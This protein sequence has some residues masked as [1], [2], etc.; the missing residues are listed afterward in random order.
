MKWNI[1]FYLLDPFQQKSR[2]PPD[3]AF[4]RTIY[5]KK[6]EESKSKSYIKSTKQAQICSC[7][8]KEFNTKQIIGLHATENARK[9]KIEPR[10]LLKKTSVPRN[11]QNITD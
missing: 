6:Q 10:V 7:C 3:N 9:P 2:C 4:E 11:G 8:F 1:T 5:R